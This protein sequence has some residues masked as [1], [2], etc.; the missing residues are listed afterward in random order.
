MK[1][2][3]LYPI[4]LH[5]KA[6]TFNGVGTSTTSGKFKIPMVIRLQESDMVIPGA[7][8][9][10]KFRRKT[11][12]LLVSQACQAKLGMT[13]RVRDG[14]ITLDA[15]DA[16]SLD[17]ARHV[18]TGLI[19]SRID[20]RM[21]N[22]Y[23]RN[24]ILNDL[25]IDFDDEPGIDSTARDSDQSNFPDC[26]THA[27]VNV[28]GFEVPRN[29]LQADTFVVRCGLAIF[30]QSSWSTHRRHEFWGTHEE[31]CTMRTTSSLFPVSRTITLE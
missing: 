17:V 13:K 10:M 7:C 5:R 31:L 28:R 15:C 25:V 1:V 21:Y 19:M 20:H 30:E 18:V 27:M 8:I 22:D 29:V 24:P 26:S 2:L 9:H 11:H 6:T 4:W 14:S 12:P 3:G 23:V 16:Q